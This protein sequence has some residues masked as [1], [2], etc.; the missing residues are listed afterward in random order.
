L[1]YVIIAILGFVIAI[2]ALM[3]IPTITSADS[4][5]DA[6]NSAI[7]MLVG[8]VMI[9]CV[10]LVLLLL[11][12]IFFILGI[13][14]IYSGKNEYGPAHASSVGKALIFFILAIVIFLVSVGMSATFGTS[15]DTRDVQEI[16]EGIRNQAIISAVL[17]LLSAIFMGLMFKF[18]IDAIAPESDKKFLN[19]GLIMLIIGGIVSI[20]ITFIML[21]ADIGDVSY[22]DITSVSSSATQVT[23]L[24]SIVSFIGYIMFFLAY[25]HTHNAIRSGA[26]RPA[27]APP[28]PPGPPGPP[29]P[30]AA[31][32]PPGYGAPPPPPPGY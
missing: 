22:N 17:G 14:N 26:L 6:I 28:G 10:L 19:I 9:A 2:I 29:P 12:L 11:T 18:S 27:G 5:E 31:P 15:W 13:I 1:L 20:A 7:A 16:W 23:Q 3:A 21:P 30:G 24:G 25:Q 4:A 8:I 32:P